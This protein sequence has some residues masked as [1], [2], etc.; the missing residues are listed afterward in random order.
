MA[1][2]LMSAILMMF[3]LQ[4]SNARNVVV[5]NHSKTSQKTKETQTDLVLTVAIVSTVDNVF[6]IHIAKNHAQKNKT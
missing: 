3:I 1:T 5:L 2:R 6:Y 4:K